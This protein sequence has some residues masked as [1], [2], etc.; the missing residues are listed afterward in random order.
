MTSSLAY[1]LWLPGEPLV[2]ASASRSRQNLLRSAGLPFVIAPADIDERVLEAEAKSHGAGASEVARA[3]AHA[4]A[5]RI[6]GERMQSLVIGA[7]QTLSLGDRIFHKSEN[8][9]QAADQLRALAGARHQLH[10]GLCLAQGGKIVWSHIEQAQMSMR[11]L[12]ETFISAYLSSVG[13]GICA[14]VGAYAIEGLGVHLFQSVEGDH[15][16]I[17]GLPLAPL[18][19]ELRAQGYVLA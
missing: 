2:L 7:D 17:L 6:S 3:L 13:A 4:K 18:L 19:A 11:P 1:P 16:T 8:L 14:N 9:R 10:S 12:S 5:L 15:S